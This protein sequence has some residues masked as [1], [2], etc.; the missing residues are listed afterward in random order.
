[1]FRFIFYIVFLFSC[2]NLETANAANLSAAN[3]VFS[4]LSETNGPKTLSL[5][6]ASN[7]PHPIKIREMMEDK[8]STFSGKFLTL[9][10]YFD[11]RYPGKLIEADF[12]PDLVLIFPNEDPKNIDTIDKYL[13]Y[14][15]QIYRSIQEK[16]SEI[17]A[18]ALLPKDP[19]LTAPDD[20]YA[21]IGDQPYIT[22][23]DG[24]FAI[25]SDF[26]K[27]IGYSH[28]IREKEAM[29]LFLKKRSKSDEAE[30]DFEH[31]VTMLQK[32]EWDKFFLYGTTLPSP[33]VGNAGIGAYTKE[34]DYKIRLLSEEARLG[35]NAEILAALHVI[36]PSHRFMLASSLDNTR[37]KPKIKIIETENIQSYEVFYP[38]PT[39]AVSEQMIG[40][41]RGDFAF[42][43]KLH[44]QDLNKPIAMKAEISFENCDTE[45]TCQHETINAYLNVGVDNRH[46][47]VFSS[48]QT[49]IRQSYYNLPKESNKHIQLKDFSFT[50]ENEKTYLNFD[51]SYSSKIKNFSFLLENEINTVF[52]D[53]EMVTSDGHIYLRTSALQNASNFENTPLTF[54]VRLNDY[55]T[56]KQTFIPSQYKKQKTISSFGYMFLL[57]IWIGFAFYLTFFGLPLLMEYFLTNR[58]FVFLKRYTI[59][60]VFTSFL[61]LSVLCYFSIKQPDIFYFEPSTNTLYISVILFILFSKYM[62]MD[63]KVPKTY[64]KPVFCGFIGTLLLFA[65]FFLMPP[66]GF[67][68]FVQNLQTSFPSTYIFSY[69]GLWVGFIL[70]DLVSYIFKHKAI[71][72]KL[73][74]LALSV[75]K[76]FILTDVLIVLLWVLL[77]LTLLSVLKI[78]LLLIFEAFMLKV[79]FAFWQALYTAKLPTSYISG[80]QN[81][82]M[83][84]LFCSIFFMGKHLS[85]C[86]NLRYHQTQ[87]ISLEEINEKTSQGE[88][89]VVGFYAPNCIKCV[90]N[91]L[92]VF[93]T[94]T[95]KRLKDFYHVTY[96]PII[97]KNISPDIKVLLEKYKHYQRPFYVLFSPMTPNGVIL[98]EIVLPAF[99]F[100]TLES[101]HLEVSSSSQ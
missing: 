47:S 88:N 62:S 46:Q 82:L 58:N 100:S 71:S 79:L 20:E 2:F 22:A 42:P 34:N 81:V 93:N 28:N 43:I 74:L 3:I 66:V 85:H 86:G 36:V 64:L 89:I 12:K 24:Q 70:P 63:I 40:A 50:H 26:K 16:I 21:I 29:E 95:L 91:D 48:V 15:I 52:T 56:L 30:T 99:L 5:P 9:A 92:T 68:S 77:P 80:T 23:P 13:H 69:L 18:G 41:Y 37:L 31:F 38:M 1:M 73:Q 87:N 44:I 96:L 8:S 98:G 61:G 39:T 11:A 65:L 49:F 19:P 75:F 4:P 78:I 27:I 97:S 55:D 90:Y 17:K 51:F 101:F 60:K 10:R 53:P 54:L 84:I 57:G 32:I 76:I 7:L 6:E 45:L 94:V 25:V 72:P 35:D 33:F 59:S 14:G 83:I 67:L